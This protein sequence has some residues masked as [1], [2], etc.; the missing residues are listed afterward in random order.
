MILKK[1]L[2]DLVAEELRKMITNNMKHG[3]RMP[4]EQEL[5]ETFSVGRST[6]RESLKILSAQGLLEQEKGGTFVRKDGSNCLVA[7]LGL[8][9]DFEV[10]DISDLLELRDLIEICALRLAIH[11]ATPE[12]IEELEKIHWEMQDP[13][14]TRED[15]H[16][17][18]IEFHTAIAKA[19]KNQLL[20]ELLK[21][22]RH[23]IAA[24]QKEACML[25]NIQA[26]AIESHKKLIQ[27]FKERN[28]KE[29]V[30]LM[31]DHL[32]VARV[33]YG[34]LPDTFKETVA[35]DL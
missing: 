14:S 8:L 26:D 3:D 23:V 10:G 2:S 11:R 16:N 31:N 4:T 35:K 27:S 20:Y 7:P 28:E 24:N 18:D 13:T 15:F 29:A 1:N 19:T 9:L 30:R 34:F 21:A 17:S 32:K 25:P 5:A 6:I 33:F 12:D 22:I